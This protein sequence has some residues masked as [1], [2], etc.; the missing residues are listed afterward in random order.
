MGDVPGSSPLPL[1]NAST[2]TDGDA[3][4]CT[5]LV[6]FDFDRTLLFEANTD[7]I[8]RGAW[9]RGGMRGDVWQAPRW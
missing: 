8:R 1:P 7:A 5:L 2:V 9:G 3:T 6:V 4:A